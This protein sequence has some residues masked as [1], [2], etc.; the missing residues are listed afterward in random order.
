MEV[1]WESLRVEEPDSPDWHEEFLSQRREKIKSG[2][3]EWISGDQL[4]QRLVKWGME[5]V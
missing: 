1:L 2:E 5:I 4:K 3:A